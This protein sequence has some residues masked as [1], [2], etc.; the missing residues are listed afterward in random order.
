MTQIREY[1][2]SVTCAAILCAVLGSFFEKKGTVGILL[3]L[4][5]GLFL[6]FTVVRPLLHIE[7]ADFT[8]VIQVYADDAEAAAVFGE[9][10]ARDEI[11]TIIKAEAEA[12]I[13]DKAQSLGAELTAEVTLGSEDVPLPVTVVL[14]GSISP[15][16]K[17]ILVNAIEEDLGIAKENQ[18]WTG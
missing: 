17:T 10:Y 11:S 4:I 2:L 5:G 13:L 14:K 3:K 16:A 6:A 18:V 1:I 12:Y 15:Y 8:S 9:N 7:L